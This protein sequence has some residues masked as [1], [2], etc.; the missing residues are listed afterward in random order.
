[1]KKML[2]MAVLV[3]VFVTGLVTAEQ[4]IDGENK[5]GIDFEVSFVSQYLFFGYDLYTDDPAF[6]PSVTFD[7]WDTG[8]GAQLWGSWPTDNGNENG[9]EFD[10]SVFYSNTLLEDDKL[11]TNYTIS[12][13][14]YDCY[15]HSTKLGDSQALMLGFSWPNLLDCAIVPRYT[16]VKFWD[17]SSKATA[18]QNG[19]VHDF[20]F[21]YGFSMDIMGKDQSMTA[22][23]D[24]VYNDGYL[25]SDADWSHVLL[26]IQAPIALANGVLT[27][28]LQ[29]QISMEDSVNT[30]DEFVFG[31]K[32][33][34]SF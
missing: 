12:W 33:G 7:L 19:W 16:A 21:D 6:Q 29:Y 30:D 34:F 18:N 31:I 26:G 15:K 23:F 2:L 14:Y 28:S 1:M 24:L 4:A 32:Y 8:F 13:V 9:K 20:G 17:A 10:Y 3:S 25:G 11:Q 5:L 27:P 22:S